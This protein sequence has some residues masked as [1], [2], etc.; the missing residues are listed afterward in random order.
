MRSLPHGTRVRARRGSPRARD[1]G[2]YLHSQ[3]TARLRGRC[4]P[5]SSACDAER[6]ERI[7]D[8]RPAARRRQDRHPGRDPLQARAAQPTRSGRS[9]AATPRSAP[10]SSRARGWARSRAGSFH[11]HERFDG[12]GYPDGLAGEEIPFESR[13]LHAADM[14]EAMTS[15]RPYRRRPAGAGG[16]GDRGGR[17]QPARPG[18][19]AAAG[20]G[21]ARA[22]AADQRRAAN[23]TPSPIG[24]T[25]PSQRSESSS[26]ALSARMPRRCSGAPPAA[27]VVGHL[28]VVAERDRA[29]TSARCRSPAPRARSAFGSA[30]SQVIGVLALRRVEE[31]QVERAVEA[32]RSPRARRPRRSRPGRATPARSRNPRACPTRSGS[33]SIVTIRPRPSAS[34]MCSVE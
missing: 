12:R 31:E 21:R 16:G 4:S 15:E 28:D 24:S 30:S 34:A 25:Q 13:L 27:E 29:A 33:R 11:L 9:C 22:R 32:A 3:R 20:R 7:C 18:G 10:A 8:R 23:A 19:R 2:T 14:L 1:P 17:R 6:I 26:S 5:P